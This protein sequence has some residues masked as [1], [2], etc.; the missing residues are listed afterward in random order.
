MEPGAIGKSNFPYTRTRTVGIVFG[1]FWK[2]H[3]SSQ[4]WQDEVVPGDAFIFGPGRTASN[5]Q[6]W[7]RR[8]HLLCHRD[9]PI[10]E[11]AYYPDSG[12]WKVNKSSRRSR[13]HQREETDYFDGEE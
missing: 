12:K 11:S 5:Y 10:G 8:S 4:R 7:C 13:R 3:R 6:L 9:N 1:D 2:R